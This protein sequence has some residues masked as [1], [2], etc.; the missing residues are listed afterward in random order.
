MGDMRRPMLLILA[1]LLACAAPLD[2]VAAEPVATCPGE[3]VIP[4][5]E[6]S[7]WGRWRDEDGDCQDTRAEVLI[8]DSRVPVAFADGEECRVVAGEWLDPY[9]GQTFVEAARID[10]DHFLPLEEVHESGGWTWDAERRRAFANDQSNLVASGRSSNRSKGSRGPEEWLPP[11]ESAR[12]GYVRRWREA[13]TRWGLAQD[14]AEAAVLA[15]MLTTCGQGL[16]PALP[17][18]G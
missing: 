5:Y 1:A 2:P 8:R 4:D 13:K 3:Q 14:E 9:T 6:R 17:Q 16:V 12:C 15:Y 7:D 18:G 11:L 10:I